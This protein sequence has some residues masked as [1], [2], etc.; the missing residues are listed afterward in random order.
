MGKFSSWCVV[1]PLPALSASVLPVAVLCWLYSASPLRPLY[2][3]LLLENLGGVPFLQLPSFSNRSILH[4][5][6]IRPT[7]STEWFL[8]W[9]GPGSM[10]EWRGRDGKKGEL[11]HLLLSKTYYISL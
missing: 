1:S 5:Q 6:L 8:W 3:S 4:S 9:T 7:G 11:G 10:E 2:S